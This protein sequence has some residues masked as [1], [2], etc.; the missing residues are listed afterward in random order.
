MTAESYTPG[1]SQNATAFMSKRSVHSHGQFFLPH[2]TTGLS[3]IDCGCGPDR[4][5]W[6]SRLSSH[7]AGQWESIS[8]PS[9]V[10]RAQS[11]APSAEVW[12]SSLPLGSVVIPRRTPS[13]QTL[14]EA[15]S[16]AMPDE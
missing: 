9:Q 6:A 5:R 12:L 1:D 16:P 10:E 4:L 7:L 2:L 11:N 15:A 3:V 8:R 14:L 13:S